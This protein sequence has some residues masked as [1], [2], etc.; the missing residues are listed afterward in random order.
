MNV[1]GKRGGAFLWILGLSLIAG[2]CGEEDSGR[3][4]VGAGSPTAVTANIGEAG[5]SV[6]SLDGKVRL[7]I[8]PGALAA[9]E[10][11]TVRSVNPAALPGA[12]IAWDLEPVGLTFLKPAALSVT[13]LEPPRQADGRLRVPLSRLLTL[14]GTTPEALGDQ[15]L[16]VEESRSAISA[17]LTQL[18]PVALDSTVED[19]SVENGGSISV[20][21]IPLPEEL[22]V[23]QPYQAELHASVNGFEET[24]PITVSLLYEDQSEP[25]LRHSP[26][27][28]GLS[29]P[30]Q[31]PPSPL[32]INGSLKLG[33]YGSYVCEGAADAVRFSIDFNTRVFIGDE[34]ALPETHLRFNTT[35]R[36]E[37]P[38][39]P[40][41]EE[42]MQTLFLTPIV[43]LEALEALSIPEPFFP[44]FGLQGNDP[45]AA[46]GHHGGMSLIHL[47][48]G[49]VVR[50]KELGP[51]GP[52]LQG[53][54]A[55]LYNGK[56]C[57][58]GYGVRG[59]RACWDPVGNRFGPAEIRA[60]GPYH[61]A[62]LISER[63]TQTPSGV[64]QLL[65]F[66]EADKIHQENQP[67]GSGSLVFE[68]KLERTWFAIGGIP[69]GTSKSAYFTDNGARVLVV[70]GSPFEP[71]QLW[72]GEPAEEAGGRFVGTLGIDARKLRCEIP[73]CAVS[74]FG[75]PV[76]IVY[77][78]GITPPRI[79]DTIPETTA[80]VGIDVRAAGG[81]REIVS[82]DST[83]HRWTLTS[84]NLSGQILSSRTIAAPEECANPR[85]SLFAADPQ[86]EEVYAV[87]S[88]NG[89]NAE[90]TSA[91]VK[92]QL[93]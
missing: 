73:I 76:T 79:L 67:G 88:C 29:S 40:P 82:T 28:P 58:F 70:R 26:R 71:G 38:P 77:W 31:P 15:I 49:R 59:Y 8:P 22:T 78:D 72:W 66:A 10:T 87:L 80:A 52:A 3:R 23:G 84:V 1:Q 5:G 18:S 42:Q 74:H 57:L 93:P 56:G 45:Y 55:H 21:W 47:G 54:V 37:E 63:I 25:P 53:A 33:E 83:R 30:E 16:T 89:L 85:H 41:T 35:H 4:S 61:D 68:R 43:Q 6:T 48:T 24:D 2:G 51:D 46:V 90:G 36:C 12:E 27:A 60:D 7:T 9:T 19:P 39:P 13:L 86:S 69:T 44:L 81:N 64:R 65:W 34:T 92:M 91:V 20:E 75:G 14:A 32:P 17:T 50:T 11:I 62:G